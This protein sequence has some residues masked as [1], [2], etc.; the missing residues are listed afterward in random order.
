MFEFKGSLE[1]IF[2]VI[3]FLIN[4]AMNFWGVSIF[5]QICFEFIVAVISVV[6]WWRRGKKI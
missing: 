3:C 4:A 1:I 6:S 5:I 2:V